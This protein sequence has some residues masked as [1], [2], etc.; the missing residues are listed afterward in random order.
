MALLWRINIDQWEG[1]CIWISEPFAYTWPACLLWAK[2][3]YILPELFALCGCK[4][5]GGLRMPVSLDAKRTPM[6]QG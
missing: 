3:L 2:T 4:A 5:M 1:S 6:A